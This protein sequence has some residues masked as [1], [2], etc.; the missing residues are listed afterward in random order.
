MISI[1]IRRKAGTEIPFWGPTRYDGVR[2]LNKNK[3]YNQRNTG[4]FIWKEDW[5]T[6]SFTDPYFPFLFNDNFSQAEFIHD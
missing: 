4:D 1:L 3:D 2:F 6:D 5:D